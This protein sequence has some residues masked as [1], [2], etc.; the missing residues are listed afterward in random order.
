MSATKSTDLAREVLALNDA[1]LRVRNGVARLTSECDL[2]LEAIEE[3]AQ[4][5]CEDSGAKLARKFQ[6]RAEAALRRLRE[7]RAK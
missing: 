1:A 4:D 5:P 7:E 3:I 2:L 6:R